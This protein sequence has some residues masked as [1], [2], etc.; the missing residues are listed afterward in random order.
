MTLIEYL[1]TNQIKQDVFALQI[2]VTQASVTRYANG[3][4]IPRP[5][6]MARI[7]QA[8]RGQVSASDFY[9]SAS[10]HLPEPPS[11]VSQ[12]DAET[13]ACPTELRPFSASSCPWPTP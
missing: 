8:T 4:R 10:D 3:L 7:F 6:I 13:S 2:G 12:S 5:K 11:S 1:R 9:L